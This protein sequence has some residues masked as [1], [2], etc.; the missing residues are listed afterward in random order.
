MPATDEPAPYVKKEE[1]Q[2]KTA[3]PTMKSYENEKF[4][5]STQGR[6]IR[7]LCEFEEPAS[8]LRRNHIR[9]TVLVFGSARSMTAE[10]HRAAVQKREA[11]IRSATRPEEREKAEKEL[12]RLRSTEWMCEW[13]EKITELSK[14]IAEFS[15]KERD[16]INAS[17]NRLPD[18]FRPNLSGLNKELSFEES[19]ESFHDLIVTT[20]GGPGFMEAA[21]KGAASVPDVMTMGMGISLPFEVGLNQYVTPGLAFQFHY[22]FTRKFWMMYSCRAVVIAPG[23]FGTMDEVFELLTLRQTQKIHKFPIVLFCVKFW[24]TVVNWEALVDY[25]TISKEEVDSLCFTD[26]VDEALLFIR[27]FFEST[28]E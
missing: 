13:M 23:G 2:R 8:R 12:Q 25:G 17:F 16:L 27:N 4:L 24:R 21:N 9:S 22:F 10:E 18:Y 3:V 15:L 28:N 11:A 5:R 7:I 26:S 14:R 20:G 19:T 1:P 6:L